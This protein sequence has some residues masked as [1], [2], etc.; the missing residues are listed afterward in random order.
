MLIGEILQNFQ[1][2]MPQKMN[3]T[4][5]ELSAAAFEIILKESRGVLAEK[6]TTRRNGAHV[7]EINGKPVKLVQRDDIWFEWK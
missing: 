7:G 2:V 4:H 3:I 6:S 5:L 1:D